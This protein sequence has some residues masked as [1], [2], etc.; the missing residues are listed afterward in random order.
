MIY[1]FDGDEP[2]IAT[3]AFVAPNAT[4]LGDVQIDADASV[5]FGVVIR[6]DENAIRIGE[7]TNVQDLSVLHAE[8]G[9]PLKIGK[10][11]TIGHRVIVHGCTVE[12]DCLIGMGAT[13][14]NGATIG[15]ESIVGAGAV[16]REGASIPPRSLIV[17]VPAVVKRTLDDAAL[18]TI[19]A[20]AQVY[21][22]NARRY[23]A[24]GFA[25]VG[26]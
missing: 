7:R 12:D 5:W 26:T 23:R 3:D 25:G 22:D 17:G 21:V 9:H 10:N 11:V 24:A 19:R 14:L 13:I 8:H 20:N 4:V 2:R 6:G 15:A 16:V 1:A 18:E